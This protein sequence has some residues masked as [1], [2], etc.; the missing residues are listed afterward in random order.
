[1][2]KKTIVF[3]CLAVLFLFSSF[4][5][6]SGGLSS[7]GVVCFIICGIFAF[8]AFRSAK[9]VAKTNNE[10]PHTNNCSTPPEQKFVFQPLQNNPVSSPG[11]PAHNQSKYLFAPI[12]V[13]G[14]TFNNDDGTDRQLI[15]RKLHFRDNPFSKYVDVE[16]KQYEF[17]G[18]PAYGIYA[19]DMQIGNIPANLVPFMQ[20]NIERIESISHIDVYGGGHKDGKPISYGCKIILRFLKDNPPINVPDTLKIND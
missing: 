7:G 16:I 18:S 13:A 20:E 9:T 5:G 1:M 8:L 3:S 14:V 2:K 10:L 4:S 15:L 6:F 11:T 17:K 12:K 19:N